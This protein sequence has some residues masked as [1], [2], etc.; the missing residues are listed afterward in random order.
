MKKIFLLFVVLTLPSLLFAQK[1]QMAA[2]RDQIKTGKDLHIAEQSMRGLLKDSA[3]RDNIKIWLLLAQSL[4]RQYAKAN[5]K[6][7]LKEKADTAAFFAVTKRFYE[8]MSAFDSVEVRLSSSPDAF[9]K[10]RERNAHFLHSIRPNLFNGGVFLM[11]KNDYAAAFTYFDTYIES[12]H[13]PLFAKQDY[14]KNDALMPHAAYWATYC[15]YKLEKPDLIMKHI[16]L[17]ERDNSMLNFLRQYEAEAFLMRGDTLGYVE[18]LQ[19]GFEEYPN[20]AFFFPR[21]VEYYSQHNLYPE[22]LVVCDKALA[23]DSTSILFQQT[24]ATV[25]LNLGRYDECID[26]SK[27]ILE[28]SPDNA[29]AYLNLG[30]AYF[31][32]AIE[33]ERSSQ[34]RTKRKN[35][36]ELYKAALPNLER[37]RELAPDAKDKWLAPLYTIYLNLNMGKEFDAIDKLKN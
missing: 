33:F 28:V 30:L 10:Y 37:Y 24:K 23:A 21:L 15:G 1:K 20:F 8:T 25:L 34:R 36:T 26:L 31:D 22:A 12:D 32:Q 4:E 14:V 6:L 2:A 29:Y 18:A 16:R 13:Y 9:L 3:N 17:A 5:E 7:Y 27:Q 35:I 11:H 19:R